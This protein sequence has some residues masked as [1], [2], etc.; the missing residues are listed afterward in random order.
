ML[1]NYIL[2]ASFAAFS[3]IILCLTYIRG[4]ILIGQDSSRFCLTGVLIDYKFGLLITLGY[5][6]LSF[7]FVICS[8]IFDK[9][10]S[11][12]IPLQNFIPLQ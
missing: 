2:P 5:H 7:D 6:S 9:E 10:Q 11:E 3:Y 1:Q 4:L 8:V 12:S